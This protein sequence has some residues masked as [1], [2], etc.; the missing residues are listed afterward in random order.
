MGVRGAIIPSSAVLRFE[1]VR[2]LGRRESRGLSMDLTSEVD[3]C[4]RS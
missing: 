2:N 1:P 4:V 3:D